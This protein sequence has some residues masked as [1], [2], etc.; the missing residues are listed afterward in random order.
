MHAALTDNLQ[1]VS[2]LRTLAPVLHRCH[3]TS[4]MLTRECV[5]NSPT[6][7]AAATKI[8]LKVW[9]SVIKSAIQT[10]RHRYNNNML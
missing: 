4:S 8:T 7:A 5:R 9:R 10:V 3:A 6:E 1:F 2:F